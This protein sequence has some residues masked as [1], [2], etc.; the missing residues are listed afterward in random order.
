MGTGVGVV[1]WLLLH[2]LETAWYLAIVTFLFL[3]GIWLCGAARRG[4]RNH[5]HPSIVWDEIVGYLVT[6]IGAP[7]G[8]PW[9][10]AGFV[11]FRFFDIAKP[12]PVGLADRRLT[13]G[14]GIMLDDLLAGLYAFALLQ[15]ARTTLPGIA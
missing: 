3:A 15:I 10:V 14:F 9:I 4:L 5:D 1:M 2:R 11:L 8:W 13:G 12:W 6:M 7:A